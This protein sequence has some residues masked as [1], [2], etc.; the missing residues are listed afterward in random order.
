[1]M[2]GSVE[3]LEERVEHLLRLRE[4]QDETGGF[5]AFIA[6]SYQPEHTDLGG[7]EATGVEY[8][9]TLALARLVLDNFDNLQASWVTQGPKMGSASLAFGVNDMGS[10]MI[11]EN[12]VSSAGTAHKMNEP[13]IVAAIR[14]AGFTPR[15][16]DMTYARRF[17]PVHA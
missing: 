2:Y 12:V 3:T 5:T 14:D 13:E 17:E 6:W 7:A 11:E 9:R 15:R 10:T 4:L 8:L 1:M 16:R